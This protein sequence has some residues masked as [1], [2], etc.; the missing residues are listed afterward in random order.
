MTNTKRVF[1]NHCVNDL[2]EDIQNRFWNLKYL[3][4]VT[5][6]LCSFFIC[7]GIKW[8]TDYDSEIYQ[9]YKDAA[10]AKAI[11]AFLALL[12]IV[13]KVKPLNL[14]SLVA[15]VIVAIGG[16]YYIQEMINSPDVLLSRKP[17]I[18]N[19]W[20]IVI[21]L[22][23]AFRYHKFEQIKINKPLA[24]MLFWGTTFWMLKN[25]NGSSEGTVMLVVFGLLFTTPL[26]HEEWQNLLKRLCDG[27]FCV[28][29]WLIA[30]SLI[31]Y[32]PY[33]TERFYGC[34]LN[35]GPFGIFLLCSMIVSVYGIY[36]LLGQTDSVEN[37][38][39]EHLLRHF[40][41]FV[42]LFWLG[43]IL[44]V[45]VMTRTLT[46]FIGMLFVV[47]ALFFFGRKKTDKKHLLIRFGILLGIIAVSVGI[48]IYI[49]H[50][51]QDLMV[52]WKGLLEKHPNNPIIYFIYRLVR[53]INLGTDA[54]FLESTGLSPFWGVLDT[55]SSFRVYIWKHF[56]EA[57][58]FFGNPSGGFEIQY[59]D[60]FAMNA[61]C[62][63]IQT[64]YRFG[65]IGGFMNITLFVYGAICS[66]RQYMKT[67]EITWLFTFMWLFGMFGAWTGEV[68]SIIYPV[69]FTG[70]FLLYPVITRPK[71]DES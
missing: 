60:Y 5:N 9:A 44:M 32:Y 56:M 25:S 43:L 38:K 55:F 11:M 34:F 71:K 42:N 48:V 20:L 41:L 33:E 46:M 10:L 52:Q 27:W 47:I 31:Y 2:L 61:H 19:A 67:K 7:V 40:M 13:R 14:S 24:V 68:S 49:I 28:S 22:I 39:M 64:I 26:T 12:F 65:Y 21:I 58:N 1:G 63:Y 37:G 35:I 66:V 8:L 15:T 57:F 53:A 51:V 18:V 29:V 62:E 54:N 17:W 50:N 30:K 36:Y 69:T 6:I 70:L 16:H 23:D 4:Y 45:F 3:K 59:Y